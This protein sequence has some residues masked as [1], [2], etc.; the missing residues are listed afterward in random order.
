[1]MRAQFNASEHASTTALASMQCAVH[2]LQDARP[3]EAV[4]PPPLLP[5]PPADRLAGLLDLPISRVEHA[6]GTLPDTNRAVGYRGN[7]PNDRRPGRAARE[8]RPYGHCTAPGPPPMPYGTMI[9]SRGQQDGPILR[10]TRNWTTMSG[11]NR[12]CEPYPTMITREGGERLGLQQLDNG[13]IWALM[14]LH[15]SATSELSFYVRYSARSRHNENSLCVHQALVRG[16]VICVRDAT[17]SIKLTGL[18]F[19]LRRRATPGHAAT[20]LE[21]LSLQ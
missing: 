19:A 18:A 10:L 8:T 3:V 2:E 11:V 6:N 14:T 21:S 20:Q 4:P 7:G 5:P 16:A 12:D 17:P 15:V 1:L 9:A 13:D